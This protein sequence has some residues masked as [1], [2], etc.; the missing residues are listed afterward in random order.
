MKTKIRVWLCLLA[1]LHVST[2]ALVAQQ[3]G[4]QN[5]NGQDSSTQIPSPPF[6]PAVPAVSNDWLADY[7]F[8]TSSAPS[9][10]SSLLEQFPDG[11]KLEY[12]GGAVIH[13]ERIGVFGGTTL[14]LRYVEGY[15]DFE[16]DPLKNTPQDR[17]VRQRAAR[18]VLLFGGNTFFWSRNDG[19]GMFL[20][21]K[22]RS[23][24]ILNPYGTGLQAKFAFAF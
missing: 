2:L 3:N 15:A 16:T 12:A 1:A 13:S 6:S 18:R 5:S 21:A 11:L 19:T 23:C 14:R 4:A 10:R 17:E 20:G 9:H 7:S 22:K 8:S 24:F